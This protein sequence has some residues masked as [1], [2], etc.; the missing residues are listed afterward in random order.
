MKKKSKRKKV[1][2]LKFSECREILEKLSSHSNSQYY[3]DVLKRFNSLLPKQ[4][5]HKP[6]LND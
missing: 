2:N 1:N 5:P 6:H 4:E 3:Q